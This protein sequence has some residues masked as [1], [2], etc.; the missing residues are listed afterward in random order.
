MTNRSDG[1]YVPPESQH[2]LTQFADVLREITDTS[3]APFFP[4]VD[5]LEWSGILYDIKDSSYMGE[6]LGLTKPDRILIR[7]D[8]YEN[9]C[10]HKGFDRFTLTHEIVHYLK[11]KDYIAL[12]RRINRNDKIYC[13]SEWQADFAAG[14]I[15]VPLHL[16]NTQMKP[17]EIARKF[18]VSIKCAEIRLSILRKSKGANYN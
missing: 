7:E 14:A 15:L 3:N 5:F 11:H 1:F 17:T 12:A 10:D 6:N 16:I 18:G 4:I 2:S 8:V 13:N 9:A